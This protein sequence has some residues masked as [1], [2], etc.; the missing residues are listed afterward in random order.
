MVDT[1]QAVYIGQLP[2][3]HLGHLKNSDPGTDNQEGEDDRYNRPC[4]RLQTLIE[5]DGCHQRTKCD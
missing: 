1:D 4:W 3:I 5:D 2:G